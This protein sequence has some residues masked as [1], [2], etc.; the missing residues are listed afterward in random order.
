MAAPPPMAPF[1]MNQVQFRPPMDNMGNVPIANVGMGPDPAHNN[2]PLQFNTSKGK[3]PQTSS[4]PPVEDVD[5]RLQKKGKKGNGQLG[6]MLPVQGGDMMGTVGPMD[7]N[8]LNLGMMGQGMLGDWNQAAWGMGMLSSPTSGGPGG[9]MGQGGMDPNMMTEG[10][11]QFG[12][13]DPQFGGFM[14]GMIPP[15]PPP[16]LQREIIELKSCT[17]FPPMPGMPPPT[18]RERPPGCRTVFVGGMPESMTEDIIQEVFE[19]C[20]GIVS[21]RMSKRNFCHIRFDDQT[22]V[23]RAIALSGYRIRLGQSSDPMNMG[24]LH[25]DYAQ[26]RDDQYEWECIQRRMQREE[27][28][29]RRVEEMRMR[30]PSPP[31][32]THFSDHECQI[33]ADKLKADDTFSPA[34]QQLIT[35]LERGDCNKRTANNFYSMIQSVNSHVRRLMN[36][37]QQYDEEFQNAQRV[38]KGRLTGLLLQ[39]DQIEKVF[40]ASTKQ[41]AW[42]HFSKAQRKNIEMW[43]KQA[44]EIRTTQQEEMMSD[45]KEEDMELSD[46]EDD[47]GGMIM[48][49]R[50]VDSAGTFF[51]YFPQALKEENDSLK[52]QVEAYKNE[53]EVVKSEAQYSLSERDKQIQQLQ[54]A[55]QGMQQQLIAARTEM[56]V[57]KDEEEKKEEEEAKAEPPKP[58]ALMQWLKSANKDKAAFA[59]VPDPD[60]SPKK[61]KDS[62]VKKPASLDQQQALLVGVLS[63]FLHVHPFG[64]SVEYMWSYLQRLELTVTPAELEELLISLPRC[65]CQELFGIGA[66]LE[67]RWKF[68]GFEKPPPKVV[69]EEEKETPNEA[70]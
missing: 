46:N 16:D 45:R 11:N 23:D 49:R 1:N 26:A 4:S 36:E 15:P 42:D 24:R 8:Q 37:R 13:I 70:E 57:K 63:S 30:P 3:P 14:G 54:M 38:H 60:K 51:S 53:L 44:E 48:K 58:S 18:T 33:L 34:T 41:R 25:V 52:C 9:N 65:F 50:K 32:V 28:H 19:R 66:T 56:Q 67:K 21:I 59:G 20:G 10:M 12:M 39:F 40:G 43:K 47:S 22:V 68:T 69:E 27:R 29:R 5:L 35:W 61:E 2:E 62:K 17:L 64:A 7:P 31:P 6:N 55:L